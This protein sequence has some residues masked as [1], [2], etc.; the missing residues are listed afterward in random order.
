MSLESAFI[1][2]LGIVV[3]FL[4]SILTNPRIKLQQDDF[5]G[6][7]DHDDKVVLSQKLQEA[8]Q[9]MELEIPVGLE[10]VKKRYKRLSRMYHPDRNLGNES[11]VGLMQKLNACMDLIQQHLENKLNGE[12]EN[13]EE[14]A[15]PVPTPEDR[16]STNQGVGRTKKAE[17]AAKRK[18]REAMR[19]QMKEEM[20]QEQKRQRDLMKEIRRER[21]KVRANAVQFTDREQKEAAHCRFNEILELASEGETLDSK[22]KNLVMESCEHNLVIALRMKS[23]KLFIDMLN[24][25]LDCRVQPRL[26]H[27]ERLMREGLIAHVTEADLA[28]HE[29]RTQLMT[30]GLDADDN[31]ILHYAVYFEFPDAIRCL[32]HMASQDEQLE[33]VLL[34]KNCYEQIPNTY[35]TI[36][37]DPAIQSCM[38]AQHDMLSLRLAETRAA[39]ALRKAG[40][41]LYSA[42]GNINLNMCISTVLAV[43]V[44]H[45]GFRLHPILTCGGIYLLQTMRTDQQHPE[46]VADV[47]DVSWLLSY[48]LNAKLLQFLYQFLEIA[49]TIAS[50]LCLATAL[51]VL[52]KVRPITRL[53][54]SFMLTWTGYVSVFFFIPLSMVKVELLSIE[55]RRG[56]FFRSTLLSIVLFLVVVFGRISSAVS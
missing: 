19:Q 8:Y 30:Q 1:R 7:T 24:E 5:F 33:K 37:T 26:R 2:L 3:Q 9:F 46:E 23:I 4:E 22:P 35:A 17:R 51:L 44:C 11:A 14:V 6:Q 36:A 13:K 49:P 32:C 42:L 54:W 40:R 45:F 28:L 10:E 53:L 21:N 41:Q 18:E 29:I 31:T 20:L 56:A 16:D 43:C 47:S 38:Q 12:E 52:L 25:E 39:P 50:A 34:R 48:S 27:F 55:T 15:V